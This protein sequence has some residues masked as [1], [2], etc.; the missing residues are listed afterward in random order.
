MLA[1][2]V[3]VLARG[4]LGANTC[5][6]AAIKAAGLAAARPPPASTSCAGIAQLTAMPAAF[7]TEGLH[8]YA[9]ST[10]RPTR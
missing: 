4:N 6:A 3:L 5:G 9:A 2:M 8:G 1:T 7:R 10:L